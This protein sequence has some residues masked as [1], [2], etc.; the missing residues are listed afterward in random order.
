MAQQKKTAKKSK[1]VG[2]GFLTVLTILVLLAAIGWKLYDLRLQ[3]QSAQAEKEH[4]E[5][6]VAQRQTENDKLTADI[7][8]GATAD[9]IE[10]IARNEL[11]LVTPDEYVFY[12][13]SN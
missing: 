4:Y 6:L 2:S 1:R 7:A 8:E 11:G 13:T 5:A 10:E 3:L 9:K 12:D